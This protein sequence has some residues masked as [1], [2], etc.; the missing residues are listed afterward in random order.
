MACKLRLALQFKLLQHVEI[1]GFSQCGILQMIEASK[2]TGS[3]SSA[4][5]SVF[6]FECSSTSTHL[7]IFTPNTPNTEHRASIDMRTLRVMEGKLPRWALEL[8]LD[9]AELHQA[10]LLKDWE[11]CQQRQL[12]ADIDPL[13]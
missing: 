7:R 8:V 1:R 4:D 13:E 12:P 6:S 10:E 3:Q 5:S 9:W 11:L 2:E